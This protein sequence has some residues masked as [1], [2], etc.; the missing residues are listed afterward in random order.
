MPPQRT[1]RPELQRDYDERFLYQLIIE[2][3]SSRTYRPELQRDYDTMPSPATV[4]MRAHGTYRP[5]LQ[6][7][8]DD[9]SSSSY[10]CKPS[11][12]LTDLNYKGIMTH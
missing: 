2:R 6:R 3:K 10:Y 7:D 4:P 8:Y 5:E 9:S 11:F 12:E 1:Y